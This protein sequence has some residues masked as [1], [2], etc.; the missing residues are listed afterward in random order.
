MGRRRKLDQT[1]KN[2]KLLDFLTQ[3]DI[4]ED[5][6]QKIMKY[7]EQLT[8]ERLKTVS[9]PEQESSGVRLRLNRSQD[10]PV[11]NKSP[12]S[13]EQPRNSNS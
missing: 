3:L 13:T 11:S 8:F 9:V 5:K 2:R 1:G 12:P 6:K 10:N 4:E 7:I